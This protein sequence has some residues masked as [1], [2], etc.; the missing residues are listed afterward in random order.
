MCLEVCY[1]V[2]HNISLDTLIWRAIRQPETMIQA[3]AF[4]YGY[5]MRTTRP[6]DSEGIRRWAQLCGLI[7]ARSTNEHQTGPDWTE[8]NASSRKSWEEHTRSHQITTCGWMRYRPS[9][10][11]HPAPPPSPCEGRSVGQSAGGST[12]LGERAEIPATGSAV[13]NRARRRDVAI[14][15]PGGSPGR[16]RASGLQ[17]S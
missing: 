6:S 17:R 2:V 16:E 9:D 3:S 12:D 15:S 8:T 10:L 7:I 5:A 11:G 13:V 4:R 14:A 1:R